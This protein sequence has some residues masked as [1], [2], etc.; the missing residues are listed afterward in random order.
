MTGRSFSFFTNPFYLKSYLVIGSQRHK[1]LTMSLNSA[2]QDG[3]SFDMSGM[4]QQLANMVK[5][6]PIALASSTSFATGL[7][8]GRRTGYNKGFAAGHTDFLNSASLSAVARELVEP[9]ERIVLALSE[10][11]T[12]ASKK[13]KVSELELKSLQQQLTEATNAQE[14]IK[15]QISEVR[16]MDVSMDDDKSMVIDTKNIKNKILEN[17]QDEIQ[18][19]EQHLNIINDGINELNA[20][21]ENVKQSKED[22]QAHVDGLTASLALANESL[23]ASRALA[24]DANQYQVNLKSPEAPLTKKLP[25]LPK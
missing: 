21:I 9:N 15:L 12:K 18:L 8:V 17:H 5:E 2:E 25:K 11:C 13:L 7:F 1:E 3:S 23:K 14:S 19:R 22:A 20:K 24:E 4:L 6:N 16:D 10:L